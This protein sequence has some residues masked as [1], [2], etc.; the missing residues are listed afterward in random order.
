MGRAVKTDVYTQADVNEL[1]TEGAPVLIVILGRM[2]D[3]PVACNYFPRLFIVRPFQ[4]NYYFT[5]TNQLKR[6]N[7]CS[8]LLFF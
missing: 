7:V 3:I 4:T 5:V 2:T 6:S 8:L 1:L